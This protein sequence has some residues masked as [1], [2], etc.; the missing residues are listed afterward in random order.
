MSLDSARLEERDNRSDHYYQQQ[1]Q[2]MERAKQQEDARYRRRTPD[3]GGRSAN[4]APPSQSDLSS[5]VDLNNQSELSARA[6]SYLSNLKTLLLSQATAVK[7]RCKMADR[8]SVHQRELLASISKDIIFKA[9][10]PYIHEGSYDNQAG[11]T[12]K[13]YGRAPSG[14]SM[15]EFI[16][17]LRQFTKTGA[18]VVN[19]NVA[20][21][22]WGMCMQYS[23]SG[24]SELIEPDALF[25]LLFSNDKSGG[26]H[27]IR[28]G[29]LPLDSVQANHPE[30]AGDSFKSG[31][32]QQQAL[33]LPPPPPGSF[34]KI[35]CHPTR[36]LLT[37]PTN[38]EARLV[39]ASSRL[40]KHECV[41]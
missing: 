29:I 13:R 2:Q 1:E 20:Q 16:K 7:T 35:M 34:K 21:C 28:G 19:V 12:G 23:N 18:S 9:F 30:T 3:Y 4:P 24:S 22:I 5:V 26:D 40:P 25:H 11:S 17:V 14:V 10:Q 27:F 32:I 8:L 39:D 15:A 31:L 41:M 6:T 33:M 36:T 38:F 37:V